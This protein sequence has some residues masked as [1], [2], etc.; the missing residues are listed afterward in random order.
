MANKDRHGSREAFRLAINGVADYRSRKNPYYNQNKAGDVAASDSPMSGVGVYYEKIVP[1]Q[2]WETPENPAWIEKEIDDGEPAVGGIKEHVKHTIKSNVIQNFFENAKPEFARRGSGHQ[3]PKS[4]NKGTKSGSEKKK[5]RR[6]GKREAAQLN[7]NPLVPD[8]GKGFI[9]AG[10]KAEVGHEDTPEFRQRQ[11]EAMTRGIVRDLA[12]LYQRH[13][14]GAQDLE[15]TSDHGFPA[16]ASFINHPN[17][18]AFTRDFIRYHAGLNAQYKN[19]S[20]GRSS[21]FHIRGILHGKKQL[22]DLAKHRAYLARTSDITESAEE[23][24]AQLEKDRTPHQLDI[25]LKQ[26]K[27][28]KAFK[29]RRQ[30]DMQENWENREQQ[31]THASHEDPMIAGSGEPANADEILAAEGRRELDARFP[32]VPQ[33]FKDTIHQYSQNGEH[34][35]SQ[36]N[37]ALLGALEWMAGGLG[38]AAK[39]TGKGAKKELMQRIE[40]MLQHHHFVKHVQDRRMQ[41]LMSRM[42]ASQG[43]PP[44]GD[45]PF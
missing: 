24:E 22:E 38:V 6:E 1:R 13:G 42:R 18:E 27:A 31:R 9:H 3:R 44:S 16:L 14:I 28:Q 43:T 23:L 36:I 40:E 45:I 29:T 25:M 21:G 15:Y 20:G 5:S 19:K 8:I 37:G 4:W 17:F 11:S 39:S 32:L 35:Q 41:E 7:E 12:P 10:I 34:A 26:I 2:Y 33:H 30:Y